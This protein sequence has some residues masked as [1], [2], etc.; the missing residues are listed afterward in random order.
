VNDN[1]SGIMTMANS[2][3]T[4]GYNPK[5]WNFHPTAA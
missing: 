2:G 5:V 4:R 1:G 3:I